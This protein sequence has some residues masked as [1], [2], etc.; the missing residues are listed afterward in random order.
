MIWN[1][2]EYRFRLSPVTRRA[3]CRADSPRRMGWQ[4]SGS[5]K[6]GAA[7]TTSARITR[8]PHLNR[9]DTQ[10]F[11]LKSCARTLVSHGWTFRGLLR[12]EMWIVRGQCHTVTASRRLCRRQAGAEAVRSQHRMWSN[13]RSRHK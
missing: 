7:D 10:P 3:A 8:N 5:A 12:D 6:E 1:D 2:A 11:Q 13:Q 9:S 4:T